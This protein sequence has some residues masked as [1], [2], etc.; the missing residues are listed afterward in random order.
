LDK[1]YIN[2]LEIYAYHGAFAEEKILGQKFFISLE[3]SVDLRQAGQQDALDKTVNYAEICE[4]TEKIFTS[5]KHDLIEKCAEEL[6]EAI[7]TK[8]ELIEEIKIMIKKPWA[9]IGRHVNYVAVE[10]TRKWHTAYLSLGSNIGDKMHNIEEA[11]RLLSAK[12]TKVTKV[13]KLYTTK[14]VGY[15]DQDDFL[16][17]CAEIRTLLN[18]KELL[19]F[20]LE[21]EYKLKRERII[22]WGP[23]TIDLD[24]IFFD[25]E[26]IAEENLMIPHPRMQDRMFVLEP[27]CEIA[28]YLL[29]PLLGRRISELKERL[30]EIT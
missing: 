4:E 10:I 28:P 18:A 8:Y 5:Q 11:L 30:E 23:R 13:S 15:T 16:N 9:P 25:Q 6:A 27:L 24:I 1:I 3:L 14:P 19:S 20:L 21:I 29:H 17:G 12:T 2:E 26:I 7:L 22:R